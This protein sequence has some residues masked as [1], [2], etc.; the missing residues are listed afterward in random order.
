VTANARTGPEPSQFT[1]NAIPGRI[2]VRGLTKFFGKTRAVNQL[3]FDVEPGSITGFLGPNGAGK[4]TTLR[5][6]LGLVHPSAGT[7]TIGGQPYRLIPDPLRVVG[8]ALESSSFHPARTARN[9]LRILCAAT[10]LPD[11]RADEVLAVVGLSDVAK[12]KIRG[13][14]MGMRQRLGL[15]A[16]LLGDPK[17]LILD[18]PA[19]GLDPDGI[20][21]LRGFFRHLA[22]EGRTLLVSSHQLNEVQEVADRVIILDRGQL[23]RAGSIDELTAGS[24]SI[25]V[26]SPNAEQLAAALSQAGLPG[27]YEP[28]VNGLAPALRV[29][30]ADL[31]H[32]GHVAF[33]A[34]AELHEL[35]LDRFDLEQLFFALTQ[36]QF[37][38]PSPGSL[39]GGQPSPTAG[40]PVVGGAA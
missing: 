13:Y 5:M 19:N 7:S 32:V 35:R 10:G 36:G 11:S 21:W 12:R 39:P 15:A 34:G 1:P 29:Q 25:V 4:T 33:L 28:P 27:H 2:E 6:I 22:S 3:S 18:E 14:S 31:A 37:S 9:H 40:L 30:S 16:T 26:R 17:V 24:D 20:R 23:I 8:A 38:A